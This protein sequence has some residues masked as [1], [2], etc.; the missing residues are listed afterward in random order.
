MSN[1]VTLG[2]D[3]GYSHTKT[4]FDGGEDVFKSTVKEGVIDI[5]KD[6]T[7][8]GFDGKEYTVGEKGSI[9]IDS[10][11]VY[12]E[13]FEVCLLTAILR[14]VDQDLKVIN[15]NLVT[16]LPVSYYKHQKDE[17]IASLEGKRVKVRYKDVDRVITIKNVIVFPQSAGVM[18]LH[19][20]QFGEDDTNLIIDMGGMTVD[21]SYF[22][23]TNLEKYATYK[24][25]MHLF[26]EEVAY[27]IADQFNVDV[28]RD[29]VERFIKQ[30]GVIINEELKEFDFGKH[31]KDWMKQILTRIKAGFPYDTIQRKT[32][33]GGGSLR[34][35]DYLPANKGI[36]VDEVLSNA[37]AFYFVGVQKFEQRV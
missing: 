37:Q 36:E 8:I 2:I 3:V 27:A 5:N 21:V 16:G 9:S 17:L 11:K 15:V 26:Y 28:D 1:T 33:V 6:S 18:L 20:D 30:G 35:K 23:G 14:N 29:A 4:V 32:F 19:S 7:V 12:D 24:Y 31:F 25:G 10:N 34:F 13:V 22:V